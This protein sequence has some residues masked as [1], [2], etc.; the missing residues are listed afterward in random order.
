M[1]NVS[2]MFVL[3]ALVACGPRKTTNLNIINISKNK[4]LVLPVHIIAIDEGLRSR[5]DTMTAEDYFKSRLPETVSDVQVREMNEGTSDV[6]IASRAE[7][8]KDFVVLLDLFDYEGAGQKITLASGYYQSKDV[9]LVIDDKGIRTVT[10]EYYEN[11]RG[12]RR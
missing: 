10:K 8:R 11:I 5:L 9:Y 3:L 6:I 2:I 12:Q 7:S 1:R 4:D